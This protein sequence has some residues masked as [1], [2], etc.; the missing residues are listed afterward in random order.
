ML[1]GVALN[2]SEP[3]KGATLALQR[4]GERY[5][6][7]LCRELPLAD[8]APEWL[9]LI[10]NSG[11]VQGIDGRWFLFN[12]GQSFVE[13]LNA[14]ERKPMLDWE[15]ASEKTWSNIPAPAAGWFTEFA[16]RDNGSLWGRVDWTPTGANSVK[17]REYR[18]VSP[19]FLF[20]RDRNILAL[21]SAGLTNRP[22]LI[23][24]ALNDATD[25]VGVDP[26]PIELLKALGL[27]ASAT[28]AQALNAV[29]ALKAQQPDMMQ[30]VPKAQYETACNRI[31]ALEA[32][33]KSRADQEHSAAVERALN[34]A[35]TAGKIAPA[36]V[37]YYKSQCGT[38]EGLEAFNK[39]VTLAPVIGK[40]ATPP[41]GDPPGA[42]PALND[43]E[44]AV[45]K[46]LGITDDEMLEAKKAERQ[47]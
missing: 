24:S 39:F 25:D 29:A 38:P 32:D 28:E 44:R 31:V 34:D 47:R 18:Y 17:G 13:R 14:R 42:T 4:D 37:E 11:R 23:M 2:E 27:D 21:A 12:D 10:P 30:F 26:M 16:I 20:D 45:A 5:I 9:E 36:T 40:P 22:N 46:Q 7:A 1:S 43:A 8:E 19:A 6:P 35:V 33:A 3:L 15:H 41:A